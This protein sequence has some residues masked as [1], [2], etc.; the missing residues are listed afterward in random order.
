MKKNKKDKKPSLAKI[1]RKLLRLWS[2]AVHKDHQ[3]CC[4]ICGLKAGD[5]VDGKVQ[6]LDAHHL[7]DKT[8]YALRFDRKNGILLCVWHHK[9]GKY[10]AHRSPIPFVEWLK[11]IRPLQYEYVLKHRNDEIDTDNRDVLVKLEDNIN[12]TLSEED[13]IFFN[14]KDLENVEGKKHLNPIFTPQNKTKAK[15]LE[16]KGRLFEDLEDKESSS[17]SED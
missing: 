3:N 1:K 13:K 17:S 7:E 14:I 5:I 11:L 6:K 8:N 16:K 12:K 4:A 2:E 9:F 10:S 15:K